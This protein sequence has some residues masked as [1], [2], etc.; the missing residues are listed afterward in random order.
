MRQVTRHAGLDFYTIPSIEIGHGTVIE[1]VEGVTK[2]KPVSDA[3][4]GVLQ[5]I[6]PRIL[7]LRRA[8]SW[9]GG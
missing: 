7:Q 2:E 5:D 8:M 1:Q 6:A 9:H 3:T 4:A